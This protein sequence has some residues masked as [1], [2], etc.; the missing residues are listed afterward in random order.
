MDW[1]TVKSL[2]IPQGEVRKIVNSSGSVIWEKS[3]GEYTFI[4]CLEIPSG[5]ILD[6][7]IACESTDY[8]YVDFAPVSVPAYG[9]IIYAGARKILRVYVDGTNIQMKMDWYNQNTATAVAGTRLNMAF[10]NQITYLNGV[11]K[12]NM[13]GVPNFTPTTNV[14]IGGLNAKWRLYGCRH[15]KTSDTLDFDYVP[16]IRNSDSVAGLYNNITGAFLPYGSAVQ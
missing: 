13:S 14:K 8:Y 16:A 15:G 10:E 11:Q 12:T 3:E 1:T 9:S 6:T 2:I 4:E 7:G 5:T